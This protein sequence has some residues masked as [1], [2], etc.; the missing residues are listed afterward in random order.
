MKSRNNANLNTACGLEYG[1]TT[2]PNIISTIILP[3]EYS[4]SS[5]TDLITMIISTSVLP[6]NKLL[7]LTLLAYCDADCL[8]QASKAYPNNPA[9]YCG[10]SVGCNTQY[11]VYSSTQI[12]VDDT[13]SS[14][15]D[16]KGN[17]VIENVLVAISV[18]TVLIIVMVLIL[19]MYWVRANGLTESSQKGPSLVGMQLQ[20]LSPKRLN[21]GGANERI[22][23][24]S[25][26]PDYDFRDNG[27]GYVPPNSESP[28]SF[29]TRSVGLT[30][31]SIRDAA[32]KVTGR[33]K[34]VSDTARGKRV[35][36]GVVLGK[37]SASSSV[38]SPLAINNF[39]PGD[40]DDEELEVRL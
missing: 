24:R 37:I 7:N 8:R 16:G 10:G 27:E 13:S 22:R 18:I 5:S 11:Y 9:S 25:D 19:G 26:D 34:N 12:S 36:N 23:V 1:S 33:V 39:Q 15:S 6:S 17:N 30:L 40:D 14:S 28:A 31:G 29:I 3:S 21:H 32:S 4:T 35:T 2:F 20:D 38:Y